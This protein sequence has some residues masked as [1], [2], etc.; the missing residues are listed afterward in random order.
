MTLIGH[1]QLKQYQ[2]RYHRFHAG[3][4]TIVQHLGVNL[5][6]DR[7]KMFRT[8]NLNNGKPKSKNLNSIPGKCKR[9][10]LLVLV[11]RYFSLS[12]HFE[13]HTV[14]KQLACRFFVYFWIPNPKCLL[15]WFRNQ[16]YPSQFHASQLLIL[17]HFL[18]INKLKTFLIT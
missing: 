12:A 14:T 16:Y 3:S 10:I 1:N 7:L 11:P 8:L 5:K 18:K 9:D 6:I 2:Y 17:I 15:Y 13:A 4:L